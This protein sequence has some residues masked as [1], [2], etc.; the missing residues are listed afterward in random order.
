M[1]R[2]AHVGELPDQVRSDIAGRAD[3]QM[4]AVFVE[5]DRRGRWRVTPLQARDT[6]HTGPINDLILAIATVSL[7]HHI[8]GGQPSGHRLVDIDDAAPDLRM[9]QCQRATQTPQHRMGGI[10]PI[11]FTDGLS[12]AREQKQPRRLGYHAIAATAAV[13]LRAAL[14]R[15]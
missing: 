8:P 5:L 9:L 6:A 13:S 7:V 11:A 1:V 12:I 2:C 4:A 3:D 14:N 15:P 10:G